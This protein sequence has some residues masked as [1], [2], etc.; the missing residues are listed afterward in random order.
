[1]TNVLV[2]SL[3][4]LIGF[5]AGQN[6][7]YERGLNESK[8]ALEQSIELYNLGEVKYI[9][10]AKETAGGKEANPD[11]VKKMWDI[12]TRQDKLLKD[13]QEFAKKLGIETEAK[14]VPL[15]K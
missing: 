3:L 11:F 9:E 4:I 14:Q 2:I 8:K 6:R 12:K 13:I 15:A 10:L 5:I 7:G 1:M